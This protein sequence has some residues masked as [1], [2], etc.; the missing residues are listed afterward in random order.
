MTDDRHFCGGAIISNQWIL[1]AAHCLYRRPGVQ[2][3]F[4]IIAG[5]HL[6]NSGGT[7]IE[8]KRQTLHES[9]NSTTIGFE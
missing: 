2:F 8:V 6:L 4:Y 1:T 3:R 5:S 9:W 7:R